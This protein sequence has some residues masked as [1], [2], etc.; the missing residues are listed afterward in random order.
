LIVSNGIQKIIDLYNTLHTGILAPYSQKE[1]KFNPHITLGYFRN[2]YDEFDNN[3]YTT[4][5][6]EATILNF[7]I[8]T[9]F[10]HIALLKGNDSSPP[11]IIKMFY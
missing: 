8:S 5:Y 2:K 4:A 3:L 11:E 10:D 1:Y 9:T 6:Q 7:D